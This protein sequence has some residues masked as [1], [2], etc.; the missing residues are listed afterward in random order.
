MKF[1]L[2]GLRAIIIFFFSK[3]KTSKHV[4]RSFFK[5][6]LIIK[7]LKMPKPRNTP[8]EKQ[9]FLTTLHRSR[10][11]LPAACIFHVSL[12]SK[13]SVVFYDNIM[14]TYCLNIFV[15]MEHWHT[16][17]SICG[18]LKYNFLSCNITRFSIPK[19]WYEPTQLVES[20]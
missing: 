10:K 5:Q 16:M 4:V 12:A 18:N 19:S 11:H 9:S 20:D 3:H 14:H 1:S 17:C 15:W 8:P 13:I 7:H 6:F 2:I